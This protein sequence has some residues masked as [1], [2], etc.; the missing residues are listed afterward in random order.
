MTEHN[1][2]PIGSSAT[3]DCESDEFAFDDLARARSQRQSEIVV[4]NVA[5]D[6]RIRRSPISSAL[7][8]RLANAIRQDKL[9][10]EE[11]FLAN[12]ALFDEEPEQKPRI[13]VK[14]IGRY[15]PM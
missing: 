9:R 13:R 7:R 12:L 1:N 6:Q 11:R 3:F 14:A 4:G 2:M 8:A 10:A 15:R 5:S